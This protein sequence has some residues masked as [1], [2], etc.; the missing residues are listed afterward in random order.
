MFPLGRALG[1]ELRSLSHPAA[2]YIDI[3]PLQ[4]EATALHALLLRI[5]EIPTDQVTR[6]KSP[7]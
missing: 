4:K 2:P 3:A 5:M 6:A 7:L 1:A